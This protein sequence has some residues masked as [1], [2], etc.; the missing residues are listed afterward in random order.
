MCTFLV[1]SFHGWIAAVQ[2]SLVWDEWWMFSPFASLAI[3]FLAFITETLR[4]K[5]GRCKSERKQAVKAPDLRSRIVHNTM[6]PLLSFT[7]R[8]C[9][10][11]TKQ[12]KRGHFFYQ[13]KSEMSQAIMRKWLNE[14]KTAHEGW[15][16]SSSK[17]WLCIVT[18]C[19]VEAVSPGKA[20]FLHVIALCK[21]KKC[22]VLPQDR[23]IRQL[24]K[25]S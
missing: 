1:H 21:S 22:E 6:Q 17:L 24:D 10:M 15:I 23:Q 8:L 19:V 13:S 25:C 7:L 11:C 4:E 3:I 2:F 14:F 12:W 20:F 18:F 5:L 16:S 9:L